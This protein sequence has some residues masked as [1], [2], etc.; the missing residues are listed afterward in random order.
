MS[1]FLNNRFLDLEAY[2]PGEQ[3]QDKK[4]IKLNTNEMPY[5]P[6]NGVLEAVNDEA[7]MLNLYP[8]P[9]GR[10]LKEKLAKA[11]GVD[12]ANVFISNGSDEILSF[13][14]MSFFDKGVSFAD[15]TYGF[16][17]VYADLYGVDADIIPLKNDL[18]IDI[19]DYIGANNVVIANPNAPTGQILSVEDIECIIKSTE[20]I[21]LIDEAYADFGEIS[22]VDLVKKYDNVIV[23]RTYS[24]SRAM[25]GARLGFAIADEKIIED[26]E[27]IKFSTNPYNINRL[28]MKAGIAA[29]EDEN[30]YDECIRKIKETRLFVTNE[31][32]RIGFEVADSSANFVFARNDRVDGRELYLKLKDR[33]ILVRHFSAERIKDYVRITIGTSEQMEVFISELEKILEEI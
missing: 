11:Y 18:S 9:D 3:P 4:Y 16:Y 2:V 33:G 29:L 31:L 23:M 14:F 21:V 7:T 30:Y 5:P 12:P 24:K 13:S 25:A 28:T 15:I 26:L 1:R 27:T 22:C 20:G 32:R 10:K 19:A 8:D 6:S 17:K